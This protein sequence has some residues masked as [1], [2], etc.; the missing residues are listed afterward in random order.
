MRIIINDKQMIFMT[1]LVS[2]C[3]RTLWSPQ[4]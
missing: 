2:G 3:F 1:N 4:T